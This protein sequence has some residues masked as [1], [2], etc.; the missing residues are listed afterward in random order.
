MRILVTGKNGY[1][2]KSIIR[3]LNRSYTFPN[4][5]YTIIGVG[6]DD[7]DLSSRE[8]TNSWFDNQSN[9]D[10]V[11]HTAILGGSRLKEDDAEVFYSNLSMF[12]N[13]LSNKNKFNQL[14]S[15]GSG[16]EL[17]KPS[18]PYGLSKNIIN[19][20]IESQHNFSNIRIFAVFDENELDTRFIKSN[21]K[22]Y[23]N[24]K[25][26][27]IHQNKLMDFFYMDDLIMLVD[28]IIKNPSIK[29]INAAYYETHDLLEIADMINDL[30]NHKCSITINDK[31]IGK[32]YVSPY[33]DKLN[34]PLIGLKEGI[35]RTYN[36]T[37]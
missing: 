35:K 29:S 17:G 25:S 22:N 7:F 10:V 6:R 30:D 23:K 11:I 34:I 26:L 33:Q 19:R 4:N 5:D 18:D 8:A 14:I 3:K 28:Y 24:N 27:V 13:L 9:F 1:I 21:I 31:N 2:G 20:I 12:Y 32:A 16:A 37:N 15:F 36:A